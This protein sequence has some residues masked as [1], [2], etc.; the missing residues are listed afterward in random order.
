MEIWVLSI[1]WQSWGSKNI[2]CKLV[3]FH[4]KSETDYLVENIW[5]RHHMETFSALLDL[6]LGNSPVPMNSPYK[7]QWR[8]A[9]MFSLICA[10]INDWVNNREA[11]DLR[12]H[13]GHYDVNVI[14]KDIGETVSPT[15]DAFPDPRTFAFGC[16]KI[17]PKFYREV[18]YNCT[19]MALRHQVRGLH[20][21]GA[22]VGSS[23]FLQ[24]CQTQTVVNWE[25]VHWWLPI[26]FIHGLYQ[27]SRNRLF[28]YY[29]SLIRRRQQ[30]LFWLWAQP[31]RDDVTL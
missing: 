7:G 14:Y 18:N 3:C 27:R 24:T 6:L 20:R 29:L 22:L 16:N 5:W 28:S 8:G 26:D 15:D 23:L 19:C 11:G 30:V 10:W 4:R 25:Q 31:T 1:F 2:W 17:T 9:L 21:H 13:R 12:R